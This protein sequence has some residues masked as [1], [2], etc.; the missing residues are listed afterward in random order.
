MEAS[1]TKR[2]YSVKRAGRWWKRR[3]SLSGLKQTTFCLSSSTRRHQIIYRT[4]CRTQNLGDLTLQRLMS[5][6][7]FCLPVTCSVSYSCQYWNTVFEAYSH[8]E[9]LKIL[10]YFTNAFY[11]EP[12]YDTNVRITLIWS[13][14]MQNIGLNSNII[15]YYYYTFLRKFSRKQ[16]YSQIY[17]NF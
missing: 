10:N 7:R 14:D 2:R 12:T 6:I 16:K 4:T 9:I 5:G 11:S 13:S 15:L 8:N 3:R 17:P 1:L